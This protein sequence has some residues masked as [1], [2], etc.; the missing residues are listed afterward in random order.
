MP[1]ENA[2]AGQVIAPMSAAA[3]GKVRDLESLALRLPQQPIET[4]HL[5]HAGLYARSI[6]IPAGVVLTGA[7]IKIATILIISGDVIMYVDGQARELHGYHVFAASAHR[8]QAFVAL[9]DTSM[10]MLFPSQAKTVEAAEEEF[11]AEAG[12]LLSRGAC[13]S[14]IITVT[15]E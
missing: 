7:L 8:K 6:M 3:I 1:T 4:S 13:G 9:T 10:T 15:G 14:N 5:F 12:L 11:T 2:L